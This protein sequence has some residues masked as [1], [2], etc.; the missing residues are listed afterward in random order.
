MAKILF[1][2]SFYAPHIGG[3]AEVTLRD[4]VEGLAA[5]GHDVVVLATNEKQGLRA[6]IIGSAKVYR[7]GIRNIYWNFRRT[8]PN[9][10]I[11]FLWHIKDVNNKEMGRIVG[12]VLIKEKPDV[13]LTHNLAGWSVSAWEAA[14]DAGIPVVQVLHDLYLLCP[15]SL[16]FKG[17]QACK[18]QC[19]ICKYFRR[20]HLRLSGKLSA[21]IGVSNFVIGRMKAEGYF[22]GIHTRVI[23]NA[24]QIEAPLRS[25]L[26]AER[27]LTFGFIGTVNR[28]KGV[29][30]LI[31]Q[32]RKLKIKNKL[33]IAGTGPKG[34][35]E[36]IRRM[37]HGINVEFLGHVDNK[38]FFERIDVCIVPSIWNDTLPGVAIEA[39]AFGVPVIASSR[40]G[41]P[42]IIRNL[43]N[44][45]LCDPD[46]P[47]SLGSAIRFILSEREL[48]KLMISSTQ[49]SVSMFLNR[50]RMIEE[51]DD[52]I[53]TVLQK[54]VLSLSLQ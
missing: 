46:S 51:Y 13:V 48:H 53:R 23:Y 38:T 31:D 47:D 11:R 34:Y 4:I 36:K 3:G 41:L 54:Q 2:N 50:A 21:A 10:L 43:Q 42:E 1:V 17:G 45:L 9:K 18:K 24:R 19:L 5:Q 28:A 16:M 25:T 40:G 27:E 8:L 7:A 44:G 12:E 33:L 20:R 29:D 30:W 32:F 39:C 22:K 26:S 49:N 14:F 35:E 6:E 52:I 37:S 15:S